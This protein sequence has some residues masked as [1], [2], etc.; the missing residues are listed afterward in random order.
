MNE[1]G[2]C[3]F[4]DNSTLVLVQDKINGRGHNEITIQIRRDKE[5]DPLVDIV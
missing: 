3:I 4:T 1:L 2:H 5:I